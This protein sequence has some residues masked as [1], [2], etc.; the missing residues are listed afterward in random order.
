VQDAYTQEV[1]NEKI[2][3]AQDARNP[4]LGGLKK[5]E[6]IAK[7]VFTAGNHIFET[8]ASQQPNAVDCGMFLCAK[9]AELVSDP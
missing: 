8:K 9:V 2:Q 4:I 1:T 3:L 5:R 6:A 7:P